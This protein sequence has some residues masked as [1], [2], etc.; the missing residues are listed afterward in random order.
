MKIDMMRKNPEV[1][2]QTDMIE[3]LSDWE[4]VIAWGRFEEITDLL[5]KQLAMQKVII[6]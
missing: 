5:E 1:C 3:N 2:F 6:K 4:S